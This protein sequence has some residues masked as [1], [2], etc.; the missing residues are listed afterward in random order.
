MQCVV[1]HIRKIAGGIGCGGASAE[2]LLLDW[3]DLNGMAS[4]LVEIVRHSLL[5]GKALR[6]VLGCPETDCISIR[7]TRD[8][9]GDH[10]G[11]SRYK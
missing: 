9:G 7:Y 6:L 1:D 11:R 8:H 2:I 4:G 10:H 3:D 5:L